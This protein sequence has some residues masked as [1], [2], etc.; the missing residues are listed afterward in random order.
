MPSSVPVVLFVTHGDTSECMFSVTCLK[1]RCA[2]TTALSVSSGKYY[3]RFVYEHLQLWEFQF[4]GVKS[5]PPPKYLPQL[6]LCNHFNNKGKGIREFSTGFLRGFLLFPRKPFNLTLLFKRSIF[7]PI[8]LSCVS[9]SL[10]PSPSFP[11][12]PLSSLLPYPSL[13][14]PRLILLL[15]SSPSLFPSSRLLFPSFLF[16]SPLLFSHFFSPFPA[17]LLSCFN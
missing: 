16:T 6:S 1:Q 11:S 3:N 10:L 7:S 13:S 15:S 9:S 8:I 14:F 17:P 5:P 4:L 2:R 12:T